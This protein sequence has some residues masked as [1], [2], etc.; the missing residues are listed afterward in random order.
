LNPEP[1]PY[2]AWIDHIVQRGAVVI[3]PRYRTVLPLATITDAVRVALSTIG[4]DQHPPVDKTRIAVVGHSYGGMLAINFAAAAP[5][6]GLPVAVAVMSAL[7]GCGGCTDPIADPAPISHSASTLILVAAD[8]KIVGDRLAH[9]I[10]AKLDTI[11]LAHRGYVTIAS[12]SHGVPP[13][14]ANHELPATAPF[15]GFD[16][17]L[18]VLDWYGTWKLFDALLA[19]SFAD[20]DCSVAFG[21]SAEQLFMGNWSDGVP[22]RPLSATD[23]PD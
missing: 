16:G 12:D 4:N 7:P 22:V 19:C 15:A 2:R 8:D 1:V 18:D 5:A 20:Q 9:L 21:G 6:A 17:V 14:I 3:Y 11:T 13:L 23:H 10:W